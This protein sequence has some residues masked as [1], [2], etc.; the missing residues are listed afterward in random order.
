MGANNSEDEIE[1]VLVP[2]VPT[3]EMLDAA[4]ADAHDEDAAGVWRAMIDAW[5]K[6]RPPI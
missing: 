2:R 6:T 5:Q 4:W 1:M 3:K